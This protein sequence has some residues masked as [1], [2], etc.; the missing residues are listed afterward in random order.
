[1]L[2]TPIRKTGKMMVRMR[3]CGLDRVGGCGGKRWT[4]TSSAW[5]A[6][7]DGPTRANREEAGSDRMAGGYAVAGG[8]KP[9]TGLFFTARRTAS[10]TGAPDLVAHVCS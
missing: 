10:G 9:A 1:M 5:A 8:R 7:K 2:H 6:N 4:D 3:A